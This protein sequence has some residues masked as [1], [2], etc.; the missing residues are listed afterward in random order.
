MKRR[1]LI[2]KAIPKN[3]KGVASKRRLRR[4]ISIK[5]QSFLQIFGAAKQVLKKLKVTVIVLKKKLFP[6][7][8]LMP[9]QAY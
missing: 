6:T 5:H 1:S 3:L 2:V 7:R 9:S 8:P 4:R